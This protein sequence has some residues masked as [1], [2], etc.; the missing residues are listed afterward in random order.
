MIW[1]SQWDATM[2]WFQKS[3]ETQKTVVNIYE[4]PGWALSA[5]EKMDTRNTEKSTHL[6]QYTLYLTYSI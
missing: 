2:R 4:N 5:S 1:G 3:K 6:A